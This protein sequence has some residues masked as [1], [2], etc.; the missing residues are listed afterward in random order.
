LAWSA[1]VIALAFG[2]RLRPGWGIGIWLLG[3]FALEYGYFAVQ[4][5]VFDGRTFG[6]RV[7]GLR[8]VARDGAAAGNAALLVRNIV[9]LIDLLVR[10]LLMA[11][12]PLSRRLCEPV[13]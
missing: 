11:L 2:L 6:K 9:R 1:L 10:V 8:V 3:R 7:F 12:R 13:F 5:V 4:E